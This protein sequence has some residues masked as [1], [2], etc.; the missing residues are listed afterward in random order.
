MA[1]FL[2]ALILPWLAIYPWISSCMG[3]CA[4]GWPRRWLSACLA[5]G[6]GLGLSSLAFFLGLQLGTPTAARYCAVEAAAWVI[7]GLFGLVALRRSARPARCAVPTPSR[8]RGAKI[9]L[10]VFLLT[11]VLAIAG[12]AGVYRGLPHGDGDAWA[13][14]N[15]R[16]RFLFRGGPEWKQAFSPLF[17][18]PDYPLLIP[19]ANA[20]LW[21]WLGADRPWVP[22]LV[23]IL[24]TF[25]T[26]GT[27]AAATGALRSRAQGLL[28]GLALLGSVSYLAHGAP[29]C[30]RAALVFLSG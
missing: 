6:F 2:V 7:L 20:R 15:Q 9:L 24:F 12:T 25:A 19:A 13:I 26:V 10:A 4:E 8:G 28:A 23:G 11:M 30:R 22:W 18:H 27:L 21:T 16:A 1:W 5:I 17:A 14:W 29:I 3:Q